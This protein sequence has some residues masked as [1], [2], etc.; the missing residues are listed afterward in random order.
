MAATVPPSTTFLH[1]FSSNVTSTER[2][3]DPNNPYRRSIKIHRHWPS[4]LVE[5]FPFSTNFP[6]TLRPEI[7][8]F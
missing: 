3:T 8:L 2:I 6:T 7:S 4:D 5:C 1:P